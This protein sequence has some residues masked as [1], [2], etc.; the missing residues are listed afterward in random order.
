MNVL[1]VD[2]REGDASV[3]KALAALGV[4]FERVRLPA[5]DYAYRGDWTIERKTVRDLHLSA[6]SGRLWRQLLAVRRGTGRPYLLV[7]GGALGAGPLGDAAIRS[8]LLAVV[9]LGVIVL[10]SG[11]A[12]ESAFWIDRLIRRANGSR[13]TRGPVLPRPGLVDR[14]GPAVEALSAAAG[15]STVT[16]HALLQRFGSVANIA[17][18]SPAE[19][20]AVRNIGRR[21][22]AAVHQ[23][24][25]GEST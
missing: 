14:A 24:L 18:A 13:R 3:P 19:L 15:I 11:D 17:A 4:E 12:Y 20:Q 25:H 22:A 9:D 6:R 1:Q 7:E 10:Q 23:L 21:R 8:V 2:T 16:A 5:G